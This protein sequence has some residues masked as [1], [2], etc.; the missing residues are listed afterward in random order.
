MCPLFGVKGKVPGMFYKLMM[1]L[2]LHQGA[3]EP[4]PTVDINKAP[5]MTSHP[6][7][8]LGTSS[9]DLVENNL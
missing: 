3:H 5:A 2:K 6:P 1:L 8:K 4:L 7:S 9:L